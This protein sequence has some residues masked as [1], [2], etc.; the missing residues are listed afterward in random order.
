MRR[1]IPVVRALVIHV[2]GKNIAL[3]ATSWPQGQLLA[4]VHIEVLYSLSCL[5]YIE[6][7]YTT[8]QR[9]SLEEILA[10]QLHLLT[11][12]LGLKAWSRIRLEHAN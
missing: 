7:I 8:P 9:V 1:A 12:Y 4:S 10:I 11:P 2:Q 5:N 3:G 6:I